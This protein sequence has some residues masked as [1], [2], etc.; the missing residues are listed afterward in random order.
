[1]QAL[2]RTLELS[3]AHSPV[4]LILILAP[5]GAGHSYAE[6]DV[7]SVVLS[8]H[9]VRTFKPD[10]VRQLCPDIFLGPPNIWRPHHRGPRSL[11]ASLAGLPALG[12]VRCKT[13]IY[14]HC[15]GLDLYPATHAIPG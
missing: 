9:P 13:A 3:V 14:F 2:S 1:M 4:D 7:P 12:G 11:P 10:L 8:N 6:R 5:R 15:G